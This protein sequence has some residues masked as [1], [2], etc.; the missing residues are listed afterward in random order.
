MWHV[1]SKVQHRR[2]TK[3]YMFTFCLLLESVM[4]TVVLFL[5]IECLGFSS[6]R[7]AG[8]ISL[9]KICQKNIILINVIRKLLNQVEQ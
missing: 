2:C 8:H 6:L 3:Y 4:V 9:V 1:K 5:S 7:A